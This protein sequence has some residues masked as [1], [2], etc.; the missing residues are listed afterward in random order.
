MA[1]HQATRVASGAQRSGAA[2]LRFVYLTQRSDYCAM[3]AHDFTFSFFAPRTPAHWL[4]QRLC[5]T[6][7][8]GPD[9]PGGA[10]LW[11]YRDRWSRTA[12]SLKNRGSMVLFWSPTRDVCTGACAHA[13]RE[14]PQNHRTIEPQNENGRNQPFLKADLVLSRFCGSGG[15]KIGGGYC[16]SVPPLAASADQ[17][18]FAGSASGKFWR[19]IRLAAGAA[20][21]IA[22]GGQLRDAGGRN[23]GF[24]RVSACLNGRVGMAMSEWIAQS[25]GLP[26]FFGVR[27]KLIRLSQA[28]AWAPRG[29]G[30]A[31]QG[32]TPPSAA[33]P[34]SCSY[35]QPVSQVSTDLRIRR[36]PAVAMDRDGRVSCWTGMGSGVRS[37]RSVSGDRG[38]SALEQGQQRRV[39]VQDMVLGWGRNRE[40]T[41]LWGGSHGVN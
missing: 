21:P 39:G 36:V 3:L 22:V 15:I 40:T 25:S 23:G 6:S 7:S 20:G 5:A 37:L 30:A 35:A 12:K 24:L 13:C 31:R 14:H 26:C 11:F 32:G 19:Q 8:R 38:G 9:G 4:Q 27:R 18:L 34:V 17:G 10:V 41:T 2:T 29:V 1:T 33:R 28:A 16:A